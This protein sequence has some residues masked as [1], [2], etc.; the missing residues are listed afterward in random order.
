MAMMKARD[1]TPLLFRSSEIYD[2]HATIRLEHPAYLADARFA[3]L[4]R[5][6]MKHQRIQH[7]IELRFGKRKRFDNIIFEHGVQPCFSRLLASP[8]YHFRRR[9]DSANLASWPDANFFM[10]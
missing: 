10:S 3:K 7:G 6:M 2:E 1:K 5:Q 9:V 8:R 4:A